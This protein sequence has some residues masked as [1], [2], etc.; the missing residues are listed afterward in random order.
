[1]SDCYYFKQGYDFFLEA[2]GKIIMR[3]KIQP[4]SIGGLI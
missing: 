1:M 2:N 4:H 3:V